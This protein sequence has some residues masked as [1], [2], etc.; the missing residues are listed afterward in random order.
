MSCLANGKANLARD[1]FLKAVDVTPQMA[2]QLIKEFRAQSVSFVVAPYEADAQLAF[3]E[4][5]GIVDGVITEDSDLL[6]WGCN[7]VL[8]KLDAQGH[9]VEFKRDRFAA[10]KG[11]YNLSGWTN[12]QFRQCV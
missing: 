2:Y 7:T 12:D 8:Y 11:E 4:R 6:V 5:E 1:W 10:G 9:C 3:L